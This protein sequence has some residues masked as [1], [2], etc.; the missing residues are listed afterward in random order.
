M[1]SLTQCYINS[2]ISKLRLKIL[3]YKD[4]EVNIQLERILNITN[5]IQIA[6]N[7]ITI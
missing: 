1:N 7:I 2:F 3:R 6:K 4:T 5:K